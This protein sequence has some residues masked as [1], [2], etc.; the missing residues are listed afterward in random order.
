MIVKQ[1]DVLYRTYNDM[2]RC[3][4]NIGQNNMLFINNY[5][6]KRAFFNNYS[7]LEYRSFD[8][9][10]HVSVLDCF[11]NRDYIICQITDNSGKR[12]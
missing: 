5:E 9:V 6:L 3:Q 4:M 10:K 8:T 11:Y 12:N 7:R 2:G 1:Y